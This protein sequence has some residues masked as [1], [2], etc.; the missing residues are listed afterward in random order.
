[1]GRASRGL[2]CGHDYGTKI[3]L[4]LHKG[5]SWAVLQPNCSCP[6]PQQ[7]D[8]QWLCNQL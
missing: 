7:P 2:C 3:R 1:M 5:R 8:T 4:H 6:T